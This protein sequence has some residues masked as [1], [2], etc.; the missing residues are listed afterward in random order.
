LWVYLGKNFST[1]LWY[2]KIWDLEHIGERVSEKGEEKVKL[3]LE[4]CPNRKSKASTLGDSGKRE[5]NRENLLMSLVNS[6]YF[7]E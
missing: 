1:S 4:I 3:F 7:F 6:T 5:K 2:E